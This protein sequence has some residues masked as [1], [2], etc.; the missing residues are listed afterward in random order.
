MV[1][2][3]K[4]YQKNFRNNFNQTRPFSNWIDGL[5]MIRFSIQLQFCLLIFPIPGFDE[6]L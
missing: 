5:K 2:Y 1:Q 6:L 4:K 3:Q